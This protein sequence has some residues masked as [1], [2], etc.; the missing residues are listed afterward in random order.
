MAKISNQNTQIYTCVQINPRLGDIEA[1]TR[2]IIEQ[3]EALIDQSRIIIFPELALCGY[4]PEDLLFRPD[5]HRKI[6]ISIDAIC[7]KQWDTYLIIG[8]PILEQGNCYNSALVIY[9]GKVIACYH[10]QQLP[11]MFVFDE[12]RYFQPGSTPCIIEIDNTPT[13]LLICEDLWHD[14]TVLATH[15][16]G[17][18]QIISIHASP[19][20]VNKYQNKVARF[21]QLISQIKIPLLYCNMVGGQD[22]LVFDGASF[23]MNDKG[24]ITHQAPFFHEDTLSINQGLCY[25][26]PAVRPSYLREEEQIYEALKL[27]LGDYI[28]KNHFPGVIIGLSGGIDSALTLAIAVDALGSEQVNVVMMPSRYTANISHTI[29]LDQIKKTNV[30]H[31]SISIEPI[32]K[33]YL[34][35][36]HP[37]FSS[38]NPDNTEQNLQARC[39]GNLLMALSNKFGKMVLTTSNRSEM[40][41]GYSTLYGDMAGGFALLKDVSKTW[42]YRLA[43]YRNQISPIIPKAVIDRPPSA[44]LTNNQQDDDTLP[45]Y[46][47]LDDIIYR[48]IDLNEDIDSIIKAGHQPDVVEHVVK[49]IYRNEYKRRQAPIG[50]RISQH[51]FGKDRRY[52]ITSGF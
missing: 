18:K 4:P 5:F 8:A 25:N 33:A 9:K 36:L 29:A 42:V 45:P 49:L 51:A 38:Q 31:T 13:G 50:V 41:V 11:N 32:F 28:K 2:L 34:Q 35:Q 48:S 52:P 19:F 30:A 44:E 15:Q 7:Q 20:S 14:A 16:A 40:A 6:K 43:H 3:C 17:A 23:L 46:P 37:Y 10:K 12:K 1:N 47:I 26:Y 39:R 22:E 27:G 24:E 21:S